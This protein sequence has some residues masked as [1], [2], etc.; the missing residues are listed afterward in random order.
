MNNFFF[1]FEHAKLHAKHKGHETMHLEMVL[2]LLT[3]LVVAQIL[4]VQ[5]KKRHFRSYQVYVKK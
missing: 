3:T 4:L 1:R 2:I 5:W